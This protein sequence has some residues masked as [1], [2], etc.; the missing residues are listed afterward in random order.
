MKQFKEKYGPWALVTGATSGIGE[1][2]S[3]EL[4]SKG[5]NIVLVARKTAELELK[6][7]D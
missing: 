3:N 1:A 6:A 4:A 7:T 2:I 5:I